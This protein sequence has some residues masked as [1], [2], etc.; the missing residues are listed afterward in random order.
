MTPR[1]SSLLA[2]AVVGVLAV[3]IITATGSSQQAPATGSPQEDQQPEPYTKQGFLRMYETADWSEGYGNQQKVA[4]LENLVADMKRNLSEAEEAMAASEPGSAARDRVEMT[5][6]GLR[7][8][9]AAL[10]EYITR[11][12]AG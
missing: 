6:T 5:V 3:G 8:H 11:L 4:A 10:E 7:H 2:A 12:S 1:M 9:I